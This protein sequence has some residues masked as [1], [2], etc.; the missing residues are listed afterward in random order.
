MCC[1]PACKT[2]PWATLSAS[3]DRTKPDSDLGEIGLVCFIRESS[4]CLK[5]LGQLLCEVKAVILLRV[6]G[7]QAL[8]V[9]LEMSERLPGVGPTLT[10]PST[11]PF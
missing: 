1:A 7:T 11:L 5:R 9:A 3:G 6:P 10:T 4:S 2:H 8:C